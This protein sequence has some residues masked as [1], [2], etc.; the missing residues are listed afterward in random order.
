MNGCPQGKSNISSVIDDL[1]LGVSPVLADESAE[2]KSLRSQGQQLL[3]G[4]GFHSRLDTL[5]LDLRMQLVVLFVAL[6][7]CIVSAE[8]TSPLILWSNREGLVGKKGQGAQVDYSVTAG[9]SRGA[10]LDS[11][12]ALMGKKSDASP[13]LAPSSSDIATKHLTM[14]VFIGS[15][16]DAAAMRKGAASLSSVLDSSA[17]SLAMPYA[18]CTHQKVGR[19]VL[20]HAS[21]SHSLATSQGASKTLSSSLDSAGIN[22][23]VSISTNQKCSH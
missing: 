21:R 13:L 7:A 18:S 9:D 17:A 16:L 23:K 1:L 5:I 6:I 11:I 3:A 20:L 4:P 2:S 10:I 8:R 19:I 14:V 15:H 22:Y 12:M